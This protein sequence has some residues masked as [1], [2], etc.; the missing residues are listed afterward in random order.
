MFRRFLWL[1]LLLALPH[2]IYAGTITHYGTHGTTYYV[3]LS[4]HKAF[5]LTE[6]SSTSGSSLDDGQFTANDAVIAAVSG[7]LTAG[8]YTGRVCVG[9]AAGQASGDSVVATIPSFR[10]N[11][12]AITET[13]VD[14]IRVNGYAA[15]DGYTWAQAFSFIAASAAGNITNSAVAPNIRNLSNTLNRLSATVDSSGNR[16]VTRVISDLP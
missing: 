16:T 7:G 1:A 15:L 11:G 14:L 8:D 2:R 9:T 3:R 12:T 10:W 5:D 13:R 6:T 4:N